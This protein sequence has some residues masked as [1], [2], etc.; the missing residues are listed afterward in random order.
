MEAHGVHSERRTVSA[1]TAQEEYERADALR[2]GA[3][4]LLEQHMR[5]G[6]DLQDIEII[7]SLQTAANNLGAV[8]R[9]LLEQ[10]PVVLAQ[11]PPAR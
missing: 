5:R 4:E 8:E 11:R 6:V 1:L 3:L 9:S 7:V 10:A 2:R